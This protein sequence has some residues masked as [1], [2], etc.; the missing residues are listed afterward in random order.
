MN[1]KIMKMSLL[2]IS[3]LVFTFGIPP[4]LT[5][6]DAFSSTVMAVSVPVNGMGSI[7]VNDTDPLDSF[8]VEIIEPGI[9][10]FN[11]SFYVD[12]AA[13]PILDVETDWYQTMQMFWPG[14]GT[15]FSSIQQFDSYNF[16]NQAEND[17]DYVEFDMICVEPG[18]IR[19]D[20]EI[21]DYSAGDQVTGEL[22]VDQKLVFSTLPD[23][24]PM[25]E[26]TTLEWTTDDTWTGFRLHLPANDFYN[27]TAFGSLNWSTTAGW[28]GDAFF[29]SLDEMMLIDLT[30]G[31]MMPYNLWSPTYDVPAGPSVNS[32]TW[33]PA[34]EQIVLEG[35]VYYV[36]GLSNPIEFLNSSMTTF[37]LNVDPVPTLELIPGTP[38][39]LQFN[40][41]PN[42][43][44]NFV[45]VTIPEGHYFDA[46][47]SNHQGMNW[48]VMTFDAWS[49]GF[50]GPLFEIYQ[51][52]SS[53]Y[54]LHD[55]LEHGYATAQSMGYPSSSVLGSS[56]MEQW[57]ATGTYTMSVNGTIVSAVPPFAGTYSR[58]NTFYMYVLASPISAIT[59]ETFNITANID[60]TPFP[61]LTEAGLTF[62]F[63]STVGPFYHCFALPQASGGVYTV[64]AL[65]TQ[66]N[67]SGVIGIEDYLQPESFRDWQYISFF[68][69]PLGYADP[70]TGTGQSINTN[71]TATLNYVSVRDIV[72]YLWVW[73]PGMVGGDMTQGVV[74]VTITPPEFYLFGTVVSEN[75][76]PEDFKCYTFDVAA[77]N[78]YAVT[79]ELHPDANYAYGYFTN[80]IG[81]N[82]FIIGSLFDSIIGAGASFPFSMTFT[83]TFTARHSGRISL[84]IVGD[85]TYSLIIGPAQPL[86]SPLMIGAL[87]AVGV[88][89]L[90]IGLLIGYIVWK[91]RS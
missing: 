37:T 64:S 63:N 17:T 72:N 77:G 12:I 76:T 27:F 25:G 65:A 88:V 73:G 9:Y 13:T 42:V 81:E 34:K 24:M 22:V 57:M 2:V 75:L 45:R 21:D 56:Y 74:N 43:Y 55:T 90:A 44:Y 85:G 60:L 19:I 54:T 18:Y 82:P 70:N 46:Y 20:F 26:N 15:P 69:P 68:G 91:R 84:A 51:D 6:E 48:S 62:D 28:G 10:S 79:L 23:A 29:D 53:S 4:P 59:T 16:N 66:Y 30:Y 52:M 89:M 71:D 47:F 39:E 32:T 41:T 58:F 33:G 78:T 35:G 14:F 36:V 83:G 80:V 61:E 67:T 5:Q 87:I 3:L 11:L 8:I 31:Q 7:I 1:H 49:F 86:I 38:L 40:T 50:T